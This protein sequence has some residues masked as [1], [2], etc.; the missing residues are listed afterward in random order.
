TSSP[1]G[2]TTGWPAVTSGATGSGRSDTLPGRSPETVGRVVVVPTG[3]TPTIG[4]PFGS[5]TLPPAKAGQVEGA[6]PT[7]GHVTAPSGWSPAP[8]ASASSEDRVEPAD[9]APAGTA[10]SPA[11]QHDQVRPYSWVHMIVL[12][13]VAFVLGMLIYLVVINDAPPA[14]GAVPAGQTQTTD[15]APLT[16]TETTDPTGE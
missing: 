8:G 12:V 13:L 11:P 6:V 1:A 10:V 2:P 14:A 7:W 3:S 5:I 15:A 16:P 9:A 4:E